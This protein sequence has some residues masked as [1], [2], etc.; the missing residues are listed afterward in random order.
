MLITD[1]ETQARMMHTLSFFKNIE[2][3]FV[4]VVVGGGG[5]GVT[6]ILFKH[7]FS[8]CCAP[9]VSMS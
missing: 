9:G 4:V 1:L 6:W 2:C 5:G 8:F 3:N 7:F